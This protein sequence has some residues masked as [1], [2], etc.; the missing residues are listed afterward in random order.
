MPGN[1]KQCR[2]NAARCSALAIRV[3]RPES[4][5]NFVTMAE[6]WK[7]LAAE[8]ESDEALFHVISE[9]EFNEPYEALPRALNIQDWAA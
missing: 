6:I 3:R 1:P 4:R 5:K 9:L 7:R 8:I 2:L